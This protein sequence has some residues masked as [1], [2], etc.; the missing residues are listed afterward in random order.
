MV[1]GLRNAEVFAIGKVGKAGALRLVF[2]REA[3]SLC[4]LVSDSGEERF[5][6]RRCFL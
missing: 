1:F 2:A 5:A 3:K 6:E 4:V